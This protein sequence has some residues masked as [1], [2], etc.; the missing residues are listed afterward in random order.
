MFPKP[1]IGMLH[2][3]KFQKHQ[4]KLSVPVGSKQLHGTQSSYQK[5]VQQ[6]SS[7]GHYDSDTEME[8]TDD[9]RKVDSSF[10]S[11]T[12]DLFQDN[13]T[14]FSNIPKHI[15]V[16]KKHNVE[17]V[18]GPSSRRVSGGTVASGHDEELIT[19][20]MLNDM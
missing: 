4:K 9:E 12:D 6:D 8:T 1:S 16:W 2:I 7:Q 3:P 19:Q 18:A 13:K 11:D 15:N 14:T 5:P 17:A 20:D 10:L